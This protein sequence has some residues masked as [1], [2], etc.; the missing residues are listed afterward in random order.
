MLALAFAQGR[1]DLLRLAMMDR[2]HQPYREPSCPLLS[3]LLS[4]VG[5]H[6]ILGVALSGA[7]PAVLVV[8]GRESEVQSASE[9]INRETS[10][11]TRSDL[12]P[13]RF[14]RAGASQLIE[15]K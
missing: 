9:V 2:I 4:L 13:C 3:P 1:G 6:G 11:Y 7:G 8:V 12:L 5:S 15:F 14:A 10:G